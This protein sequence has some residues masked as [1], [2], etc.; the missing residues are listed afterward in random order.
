MFQS[1]WIEYHQGE[2]KV[3]R[4]SYYTFNKF[5]NYIYTEELG[6]PIGWK[7]LLDLADYY[8]HAQLKYKCESIKSNI[9]KQNRKR[10]RVN[11]NPPNKK[12]DVKRKRR[13]IFPKVCRT[14]CE[15]PPIEQLRNLDYDIVKQSRKRAHGDENPPDENRPL[16]KRKSAQLTNVA[17]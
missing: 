4:Y 11:K 1:H 15:C 16:V 3:Q 14:C 10:A 7:Q 13:V 6:S 8:G 2:F 17:S 5:L 9:G 12:T